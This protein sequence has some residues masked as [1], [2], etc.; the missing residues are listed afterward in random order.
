MLH[1]NLS[2]CFQDKYIAVN[3]ISVYFITSSLFQTFKGIV[4]KVF[5]DKLK[6]VEEGVEAQEIID[7]VAGRVQEAIG[8]Q[9][10][11]VE[12]Y[13]HRAVQDYLPHL[14]LPLQQKLLTPC[15]K[16]TIY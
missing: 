5:K 16:N 6:E 4:A 7:V 3:S 8:E 1:S 14:V 13:N 11:K 9:G 15:L 10:G 2:I 12:L